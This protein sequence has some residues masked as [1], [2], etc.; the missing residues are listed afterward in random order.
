MTHLRFSVLALC[1]TLALSLPALAQE[2][3]NNESRKADADIVQT[4]MNADN[5]T[6]LVSAL[7]AADLVEALQGEGPFTVFAPTDEAFGA[8]PEGTLD[9][10][11]KPENKAQLQS[12]LKYHVVSGKVKAEK[13]TALKEAK[14]L[15]GA[16]IGIKTADGTV[17]L[18]G[19]NEATVT[20]TDVMASNGVIHVID[21]VLMPPAQTAQMDDEQMKQR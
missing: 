20:T 11:L 4:A 9:D 10:L 1:L 12:I 3:K 17:M 13:V 18:T 19:K 21:T 15:Q 2:K 6:T 7:K 5:F 16:N 14:T 8:L